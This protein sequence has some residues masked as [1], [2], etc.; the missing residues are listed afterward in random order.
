M[1]ETTQPIAQLRHLYKNMVN[2]GVQNADSAKRVAEGLLGPAIATLE[3]H[4]QKPAEIEHVAGDVSKN[5]R[6]SNMAQAPAVPAVRPVTP[7]QCPKCY[8]LWLHWPKEQSGFEMDTLNCRSAD[9]CH[10]CEKGGVEQLQRLERVPA[11]LAAP[12]PEAVPDGFGTAEHWKEKAQY[13]AGVAH[14]LRGQA[15]R[16]EPVDGII[17]PPKT[18]QAAP[19]VWKDHNTAKMVNDLRDVAI[20]YH[21]SQQLRERVARIVRPLAAPQPEAQAPAVPAVPSPGSPNS[22]DEL[23]RDLKNA[24]D[25]ATEL[26][27]QLTLMEEHA[28]GEVWRWQ[29][30]GADDLATMGNR[31]GVLIYASDLRNLL[32]AALQPEADEALRTAAQAVVDRWD[33]PLWKD[34]PSTAEYIGRLRVALAAPQHS[35][36]SF[37]EQA[38]R[39]SAEQMARITL[40]A[41]TA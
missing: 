36:H 25:Q 21:G 27:Q 26:R 33:T 4:V 5:G 35:S 3:Q 41:K 6:E 1:T 23:A 24:I 40:K 9:H 16:G 2:G 15:L 34:V 7:Y 39:W 32:A 10:Y 38:A 30:D 31:M 13:W 17:Q 18:T 28:R 20:K 12:Q 19:A 29:S 8:A 11:T 14:K 22:A 37:A